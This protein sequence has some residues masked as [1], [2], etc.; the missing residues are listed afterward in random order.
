MSSAYARSLYRGILEATPLRAT[1]L[2]DEDDAAE[3][4]LTGRGVDAALLVGVVEGA[5]TEDVRRLEG[6]GWGEAYHN[7]VLDLA[8]CA[9]VGRSSTAWGNVDQRMAQRRR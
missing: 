5:W 4:L 6:R 7:G 1:D 2:P 3:G 8:G 9:H